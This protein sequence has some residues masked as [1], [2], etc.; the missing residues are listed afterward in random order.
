MIRSQKG[1][2]TIKG[3]TKSIENN[4]HRAVIDSKP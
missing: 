1:K 3:G 4:T 2:E